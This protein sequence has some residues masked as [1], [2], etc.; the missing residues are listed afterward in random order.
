MLLPRV[1]L[2]KAGTAEP[3]IAADFGDYDAWFEATLDDGAQRCDVVEAWQ[4]ETLPRASLYGGLVITGSPCSVRDEAPWMDGLARWALAAAAAGVP[5]LGVC[6]GHQ[7]LGE[8]LGGRVEK[9]PG[10]GEHGSVFVE[11]T[12]EGRR[13]PLFEGLNPRIEVLS[14][15]DD[16]VVTAPKDQG[17]RRLAGNPS[18][19]WQAF[20]AG[21]NLR[22]VQFHPEFPPEALRQLMRLRGQTGEVRPSPQGAQVLRNWDRHW[23]RRRPDLG[24]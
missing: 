12:E 24:R 5:V 20:A 21:P 4:G 17:V 16:A 9:N 1:L 2:I 19:A 15:H 3:E 13:D 8:A 6:F 14:S 22:A 10:G 18:A 7:L 11:L 23:V